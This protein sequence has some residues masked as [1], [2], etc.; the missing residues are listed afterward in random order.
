M[1][2]TPEQ[3]NIIRQQVDQSAIKIE[4]LRDDVLDHLCCVAEMLMSKGKS[5]EHSLHEALQDLAPNGLD[6]IQHKTVFLL[7]S[8]KIILMKKLMYLVGL[9]SSIAMAMGLCFKILD[10]LGGNELIIYGFISFTLLF[11]PMTMIDKLKL[12]IQKSLSEKLRFILGSLSAIATGLA[13]VFKILHLQGADFLLLGGAVIF[14]FGF[15]P[16]LFFTNYRKAVE[17]HL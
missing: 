1:K 12:K 2:L 6:E 16:F 8:N 11:L 10:W 4:S 14:S 13:V 3:V 5:F 7:N 9:G 15:L 17:Q